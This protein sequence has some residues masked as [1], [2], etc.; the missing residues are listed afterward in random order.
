MIDC[1]V[2]Y[3]GVYHIEKVLLYYKVNLSKISILSKSYVQEQEGKKMGSITMLVVY[4]I[5]YNV[6]F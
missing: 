4:C 2:P 3:R 5:F 6:L 1:D